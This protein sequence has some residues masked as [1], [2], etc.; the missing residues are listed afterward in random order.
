VALKKDRKLIAW[1]STLSFMPFSTI[2]NETTACICGCLKKK[3][4]GWQTNKK[5]Y[6][7]HN[8]YYP[9]RFCD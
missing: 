9:I 8:K 4:V 5:A 3:N 2:K 7:K 1:I 6:K